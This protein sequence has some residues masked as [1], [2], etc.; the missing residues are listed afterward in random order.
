MSS[1][2]AALDEVFHEAVSDF[3]LEWAR[4]RLLVLGGRKFDPTDPEVPNEE[5]AQ[6][7]KTIV[8]DRPILKGRLSL[9]M[10]AVETIIR[11]LERDDGWGAALKDL[12]RLLN[13]LAVPWIQQVNAITDTTE[14]TRALT[15]LLAD[16]R[17]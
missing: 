10:P 12:L 15:Q 5:V 14:R 11:Y 16:F 1:P 2:A 17:R 6:I 4:E 3:L 7:L 9:D 8:G 13:R